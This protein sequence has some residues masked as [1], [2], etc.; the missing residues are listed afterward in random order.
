M[1]LL[2]SGTTTGETTEK[3]MNVAG[4]F[5]G[6]PIGMD[7]FQEHFPEMIKVTLGVHISA[8]FWSILKMGVAPLRWYG[9]FWWYSKSYLY[10]WSSAHQPR[11]RVTFERL[12]FMNF[13][14][15]NFL[16]FSRG[17]WWGAL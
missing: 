13:A 4:K 14:P 12:G 16:Q 9:H 2:L 11:S 15:K 1:V 7:I 3:D 10:A 6:G 5:S 8:T 17:A